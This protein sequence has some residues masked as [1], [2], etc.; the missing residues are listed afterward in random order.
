MFHR[1]TRDMSLTEEGQRL[2]EQIHPAL[3][4]I[5]QAVRSMGQ[6]Q[7]APSGLLRINTSRLAAR[8]LIEPHLAEFFA[9]YPQLKLEIVMDDGFSSIVADGCDAGIRIGESLAQNVVAVPVSPS[10]EMA[11]V[12]SPDYFKRKGIPKTPADLINHDCVAYRHASSGA[13]FQWEFNN[14][15]SDGHALK[16]TPQGTL[17]TNDD[18]SMIRAAVQGAGIIQHIDIA[19][20]QQLADGSL[21]RVLQ[22]WC[23]PFAGFYLYIPVRDQMPPKV[24]ALMDFLIEKRRL[25]EVGKKLG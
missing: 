9:R 11:V 23:K 5:D 22:K 12:A 2:F 19:V 8:N 16:V 18:D 6:T 4:T 10:L 25:L 21:K 13:I 14:P 1:T 24:R 3:S 17:I 7:A 15:E 20:R